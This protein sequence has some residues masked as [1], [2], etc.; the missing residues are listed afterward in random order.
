MSLVRLSIHLSIL[1]HLLSTTPPPT[2][3]CTR[4]HS[5]AAV[6]ERP[7]RALR[8]SFHDE[9]EKHFWAIVNM[10]C[11]HSNS[12]GEALPRQKRTNE[13]GS[14]TTGRVTDSL[15]DG[16]INTLTSACVPSLQSAVTVKSLYNR[17]QVN[18]SLCTSHHHWRPSGTAPLCWHRPA[19]STKLLENSES[20]LL[21]LRFGH[22]R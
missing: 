1:S 13:G 6:A 10:M 22:A 3:C 2:T 18:A 8:I 20:A 4:T 15:S 17:L 14:A 16:A 9:V 12:C 19:E 11:R 5:F 21:P 7:R